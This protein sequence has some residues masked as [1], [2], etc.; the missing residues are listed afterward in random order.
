MRGRGIASVVETGAETGRPQM[1][2]SLLG[3]CRV[4]VGGTAIDTASSRRTRGLLAYL[5]T[6]RRAPVPRDVLMDVFWPAAAPGA[7]RNSLHVALSG[8]RQV[9]REAC[10]EP[11]IERHFDT[12]ALRPAVD[13]WVDVE[14]FETACGNARRAVAAGDGATAERAC[15]L[16]C[17][18]YAGDLLAGD[19]YL[20][21]ALPMR[22][23]LRR[24]SVEAQCSL[25]ELYLR[26]GDHGPA[27]VLGRA[28]LAVDPA[29][30]AVHRNL[31]VC[32]AA[33]GQRHLALAQYQRLARI[34]WR[35]FRVGPAAESTAL[36]EALRS[37]GPYRLP[38]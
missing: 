16:A 19:P 7:A 35:T 29:N 4:A 10:P 36:Y 32:L 15:E 31:M 20:D 11:L 17:Q 38:A 2:A 24:E 6:H 3:G 22:D 14:E 1:V 28:V 25:M 5:L 8:V 34:L 18:L 30:E 33:T 26:R 12:Y 9:L 23:R 21:W 27:A 37:G 13:V